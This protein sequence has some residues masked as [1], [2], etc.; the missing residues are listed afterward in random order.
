MSRPAL[1]IGLALLAA[2][3]GD[4]QPATVNDSGADA[5]LT[6][7]N[8]VVGDVTAID[9]ATADDANMAADVPAPLD[10]LGND[11]EAA[12]KDRP[13]TERPRGRSEPAR[14]AGSAADADEAPAAGG[15]EA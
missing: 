10:E 8:L 15:N 5:A 4:Q 9:A 14:N 6:Q 3:C 2:A 11:G 12:A 7:E 1:I 13:A